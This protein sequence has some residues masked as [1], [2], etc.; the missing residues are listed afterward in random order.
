MGDQV[1]R[2]NEGAGQ[3]VA[4]KWKQAIAPG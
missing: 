2:E 3:W 1:G 4:G